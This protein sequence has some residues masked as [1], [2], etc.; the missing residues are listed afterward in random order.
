MTT[1]YTKGSFTHLKVMVDRETKQFT[2]FINGNQIE[3]E[4]NA[5]YANESSVLGHIRFRINS[6]T[7]AEGA[8][9]DLDTKF[10]ID[11][12]KIYLTD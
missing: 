6:E 5:L 1:P 7:L 11:N 12:V 2:Y 10:Y 8:T 3:T 4:V 9:Q